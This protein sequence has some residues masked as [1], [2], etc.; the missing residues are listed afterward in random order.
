[1][2]VQYPD[3]MS[4]S[5]AENASTDG[6]GNWQAGSNGS[7][8]S[9]NCRYEPGS[10][11]GFVVATDG[12]RINYTGIAYL[13]KTAPEI[14]EGSVVQIVIKREGQSDIVMKEKALRFSRGQLN[15]RVWL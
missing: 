12:K 3:V 15:A 10:G 8:T 14:K 9:I 1:M 7:T 2:I 4:F 13:P 5:S 11:Y 6:S